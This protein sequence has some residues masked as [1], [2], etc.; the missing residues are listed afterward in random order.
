[1]SWDWYIKYL[2][3]IPDIPEELLVLSFDELV[4]TC[5]LAT[6]PLAEE[7]E[8]YGAYADITPRGQ[9]L[10][11]FLQP[12]FD[13]EIVTIIYQHIGKNIIKHS[14]VEQVHSTDTD[15]RRVFSLNYIIDAGGDNVVTNW[16]DGNTDIILHS[17]VL[18]P[19][20]WH[21]FNAQPWHD[22]KNITGTRFS[23]CLQPR[24][25]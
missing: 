6:N 17:E 4:N 20:I 11:D 22:V 12:H 14:G 13:F 1:M 24:H 10:L 15:R 3:D 7:Q 18:K 23:M 21:M 9:L 8:I 2:P 16:Y 19:R 5:H 25:D